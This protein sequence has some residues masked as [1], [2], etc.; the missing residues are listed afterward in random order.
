[1]RLEVLVR[2]TGVS[3]HQ[4]NEVIGKCLRDFRYQFDIEPFGDGAVI[5]NH[6]TA[7]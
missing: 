5:A 3:A 1:M 7:V 4:Q 6:L 2:T